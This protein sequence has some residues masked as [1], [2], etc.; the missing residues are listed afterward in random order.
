MKFRVTIGVLAGGFA[1]QQLAFAHLLDVAAEAD[2]D[3]V[4][5]LA[6]PFGRRLTHYFGADDGPGDVAENTV[7]LLLPGSGVPLVETDRLRVVGRFAGTVT[8]AL[9]PERE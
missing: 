8:R 7:I 5:V 4:D 2:F 9:I 6:R 3:Q 1:S